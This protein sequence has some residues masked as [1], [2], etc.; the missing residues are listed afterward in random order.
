MKIGWLTRLCVIPFREDN[1]AA[2]KLGDNKIVSRKRKHI[3]LRHHVVRYHSSKGTIELSHVP[4]SKMIAD[5]LTKCL[6]SPT[7]EKLREKVMTDAHIK[8]NDDRYDP[9]YKRS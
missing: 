9:I 5:M 2:I 6:P 8:C 1:E 3:D 7:F 4:T